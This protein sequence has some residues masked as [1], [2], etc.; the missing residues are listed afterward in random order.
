MPR[1]DGQVEMKTQ[2]A[3]LRRPLSGRR[4]RA[5]KTEQT[6]QALIDA[7][8]ELVGLHGYAETSVA[9]ITVQAQVAQGTFYNYFENRQEIF[10]LLP[11]RYAE[12]MLH[13]ISEK[14]DPE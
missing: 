14:M 2:S 12:K 11:P 1:A 8:A 9:L 7:A 13:Y 3:V 10:D 5:E 6:Q 4:T